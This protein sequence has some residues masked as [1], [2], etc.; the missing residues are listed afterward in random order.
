VGLSHTEDS[1]RPTGKF[2][3]GL[4]QWASSFYTCVCVC[5]KYIFIYI[6]THTEECRSRSPGGLRRKS[7]ATRLLRLR[8]RILLKVWVFVSCVCC[9]SS[10][11]SDELMAWPEESYRARARVCVWDLGSS[12]MRRPRPEWGCCATE[13][14]KILKSAEEISMKAAVMDVCDSRTGA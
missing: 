3:T 8:V 1:I 11:L 13:K 12:T 2:V 4:S 10:G 14:K 5:V 7:G 9:V 6:Y